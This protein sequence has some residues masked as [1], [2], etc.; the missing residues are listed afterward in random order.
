[1]THSAHQMLPPGEIDRSWASRA[2]HIFDR[3]IVPAIAST[4]FIAV[5]LV[6]A[7]GILVQLAVAGSYLT[8]LG[9]LV[10]R[11]YKTEVLPKFLRQS[12]LWQIGIVTLIALGVMIAIADPV[13]AFLLDRAEN[14]MIDIINEAITQGTGEV[15]TTQV[16]SVIKLVFMII[17]IIFILYVCG[18]LVSVITSAREGSD[19]QTVARTPAIVIAMVLIIDVLSILIVPDQAGGGGGGGGAP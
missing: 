15:E 9:I 7:E 16:E 17:R 6:A 19:W 10:V 14:Y 1:M 4:V 3:Y 2:R 13:H 12:K 11:Q 5:A 8:L 18:A